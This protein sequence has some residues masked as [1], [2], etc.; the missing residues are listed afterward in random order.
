MREVAMTEN[1]AQSPRELVEQLYHLLTSPSV[2]VFVSHLAPDVVFEIPFAVPDLPER[3]QG[4]EAVREHLATRWSRM[5]EIRI[6]GVYPT[7]HATTDPEVFVVE[8][9]IDATRG[10]ERSRNRTSVAVLRIRD[11]KVVEFRD[12]MNTARYVRAS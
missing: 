8:N 11:G 5:H 1:S 12:Y 3:M 4:R 9:E 6:H 7:I 2:D 10:G